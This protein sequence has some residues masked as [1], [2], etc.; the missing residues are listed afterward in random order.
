VKDLAANDSPTLK[1]I[2][3]TYDW[4][5]RLGKMH[6]QMCWNVRNGIINNPG[7]SYVVSI[8]ML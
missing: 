5:V 4:V 8:F 3:S 6:G 2:A 7:R 1:S